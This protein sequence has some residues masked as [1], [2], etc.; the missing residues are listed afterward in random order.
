MVYACQLDGSTIHL[1]QFR[2]L[3]AI[4]GTISLSGQLFWILIKLSP[5]PLIKELP[6]F[7]YKC[8]NLNSCSSISCEDRIFEN[9]Q[10]FFKKVRTP[11]KFKKD[12]NLNLFQNL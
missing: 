3:L 6:I 9:L 2:T 10:D 1:L 7:E 4:V 12:S 11:L 8:V 5:F